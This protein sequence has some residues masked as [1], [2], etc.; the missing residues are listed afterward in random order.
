MAGRAVWIS[1]RR[2]GQVRS[3]F[4]RLIQLELPALSPLHLTHAYVRMTAAIASKGGPL[5]L[6]TRAPFKPLSANAL[7]SLTRKILQSMGVPTEHFGPHSTR[8]AG[9]KCIKPWA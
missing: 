3:R 7:G 1:V 4:E 2:K 6:S 8:G 5:F 9:V